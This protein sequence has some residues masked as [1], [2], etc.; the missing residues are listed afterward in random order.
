MGRGARWQ[1]GEEVGRK[2]GRWRGEGLTNE[3]N[4]TAC[5]ALFSA[6]T[7]P[8]PS[9]PSWNP[10]GT[11][12]VEPWWNPRGTL[13]QGRPGPPRSLSELRPQSFQPLG[14]QKTERTCGLKGAEKETK[15]NKKGERSPAKLHRPSL[16]PGRP[17][18]SAAPPAS[19]RTRRG[20]CSAGPPRRRRRGVPPPRGSG[21][22]WRGDMA[23][24]QKPNRALS[25]HA[26]PT[27]KTD[28]HGHLPRN[29]TIGFDPQP[30]FKKALSF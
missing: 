6:R 30:Y 1:G 29:G 7:T 4:N 27:T 18:S 5:G 26:N 3:Q 14:G 9:E 17:R 21:R 22:H 11:L 24:G 16:C 25:E 12:V 19:G 8:Q 23:M 13:P 2:V 10:G 15:T 28:Q 20:G